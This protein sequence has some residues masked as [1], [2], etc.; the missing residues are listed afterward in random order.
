MAQPDRAL[1]SLRATADSDAARV[2][3]TPIT[4]LVSEADNDTGV[5]HRNRG[6]L[7]DSRQAAV[8]PGGVRTPRRLSGANRAHRELR[9]LQPAKC[10][11]VRVSARRRH[12]EQ[13]DT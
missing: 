9:L 7:S 2:V 4:A 3:R 10:R 11:A 1:V 6:A 12:T 8:A 13:V 5:H